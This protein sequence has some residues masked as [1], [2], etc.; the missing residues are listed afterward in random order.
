MGNLIAAAATFAAL[1][2]LVAGTRLRDRIVAALGDERPYLG[3]FSLAS[4]AAIVWLAWA[5]SQA[6]SS[7]AN[8]GYWTT[9][10]WLKWTCGA[11]VLIAMLAIMIGL[12][13]PNPTAVQQEKLLETSDPARGALRITRHPFLWGIALWS[14]AHIT[15]NGDRASL[16][17]FST[18]LIVSV[19]GTWS[20]DHK[21]RRRYGA[22]WDAFARK[23][24]NIPF[25]AILSGRNEL[26]I[27]EIGAW[28][29]AVALAVYVGVLL[30]HPWLFDAA[31][32][33]WRPF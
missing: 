27:G 30:A 22:S 32:L 24:S 12:T 3:L 33:P 17:L 6:F 10:A 13:T 31:P 18:F 25:A 8:A 15:A 1:H 23:T 19:V 20:I 26:R 5:Y 29:I 9:P 11:L 14:A 7:S 4:L 2:L 16:L 28:R 21:R